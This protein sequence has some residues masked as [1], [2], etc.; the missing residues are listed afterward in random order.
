MLKVKLK[1]ELG[2]ISILG[3]VISNANIYKLCSVFLYGSA[4][5]IIGESKIIGVFIIIPEEF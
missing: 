1:L 3:Q 4:S 2:R 5:K